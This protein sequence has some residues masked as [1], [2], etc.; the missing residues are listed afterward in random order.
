M[1]STNH[2]VVDLVSLKK[3]M[4]IAV[5]HN[6][7]SGGGK[8]ALYHQVQGL[9]KRGHTVESWCPPTADQSF[10]PLGRLIP[11]HITALTR[12]SKESR[13]PVGRI[14]VL[15]HITVS[16]LKALDEHCRRCADEIN[17]GGYD[18]LFANSTMDY[19]VAPIARYV[20]I[21]KIIYLQEPCRLLYEAS[22]V[23]PWTLPALSKSW[24]RSLSEIRNLVFDSLAVQW[25]RV[26]AREELLNAFE[27]DTI[28]V[29]SLYSRE[30]VLRAYGLDS[31]LCP[32]GIDTSVFVDQQLPRGDFVI[33]LGD[34]SPNKNVR[35]AIEAL[36]HVTGPRPRLVWVGNTARSDYLKEL[37][38]YARSMAVDFSPRLNVQDDELVELLNKALLMVYAPRLEPFGFAPLEAGACGLPVVAVAEGGV[39]ETIIHGANGLLV[40]NDPIAVAKAI[41][42]LL[43]NPQ[44][45]RSLGENAC[46]IVAERWS[47]DRAH[48][49]LEARFREAVKN[50]SHTSKCHFPSR[51]EYWKTWAN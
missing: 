11:E 15:Y 33:G 12:Y 9:I 31:R 13:N 20:D 47:L 46:R 24:W 21:P 27:F 5:W 26:Q 8:R 38:S 7:P 32:L 10:M 34:I 50:G 4:R 51:S 14:V 36:A 17:R 23:F 35:F 29:N 45:A 41:Q 28:L 3:P 48:E 6:L 25:L 37:E 1:H 49:M 30:S 19:A 42:D 39:R 18:L 44:L 16:K 43:K 22:P 40:E 2:H